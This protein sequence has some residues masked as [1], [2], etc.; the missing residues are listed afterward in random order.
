MTIKIHK[1]DN[2]EGIIYKIKQKHTKHTTIYTMLK[3]GTNA[4]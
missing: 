1:H 4:I 2:K 3:C